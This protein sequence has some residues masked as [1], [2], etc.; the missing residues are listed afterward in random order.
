MIGQPTHYYV[1]VRITDGN[2]LQNQLNEAIGNAI[3]EGLMNPGRGVMV[4]RHDLQTFSVELTHD[5]PYGTI[6]ERETSDLHPAPQAVYESSR[7]VSRSFYA[8]RTQHTISE[9][10]DR[11]GSGGPRRNQPD[12]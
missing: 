4:T 7:P 8:Q 6:S 9:P 1:E 2:Q 11:V 3:R 10:A 5:V 12:N